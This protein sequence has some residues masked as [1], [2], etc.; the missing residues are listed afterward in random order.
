MGALA[1]GLWSPPDVHRTEL[2]RPGPGRAIRTPRLS[3][4]GS[5]TLPKEEK[6]SWGWGQH[7][8]RAPQSSPALCPFSGSPGRRAPPPLQQASPHPGSPLASP[9]CQISSS[10]PSPQNRL[11]LPRLNHQGPPPQPCLSPPRSPR[12]S[13]GSC[14]SHKHRGN[15]MQPSIQPRGLVL[16]SRAGPTLALHRPTSH[17]GPPLTRPGPP[18]H[19]QVASPGQLDPHSPLATQPER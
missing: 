6:N 5:H 18:A 10:N 19:L 9:P 1:T 13:P 8:P 15:A 3:D 4:P 7:P 16:P 2:L 17:P 11:P 14:S 12:S